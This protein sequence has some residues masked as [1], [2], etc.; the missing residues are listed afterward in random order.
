MLD[1]RLHRRVDRSY[2]LRAALARFRRN[3]R[4]DEQSIEPG[5]GL[6]KALGRS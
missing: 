6:A 2:V 5:I 3:R 1:A 4:D